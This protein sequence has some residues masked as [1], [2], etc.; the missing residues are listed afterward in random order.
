[1]DLWV[2]LLPHV[3]VFDFFGD[4]HLD[5]MKNLLGVL[6]FF[7]LLNL[8][9]KIFEKKSLGWPSPDLKSVVVNPP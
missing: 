6:R 3:F 4:F 7:P 8:G 1:M 9:G 2:G 5:S